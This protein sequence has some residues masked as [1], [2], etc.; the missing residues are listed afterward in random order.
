MQ[1]D[2]IMSCLAYEQQQQQQ[3]HQQIYISSKHK[4]DYESDEAFG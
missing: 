3:Q 2:D 4:K 1:F